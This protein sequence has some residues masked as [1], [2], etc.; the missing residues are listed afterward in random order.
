MENMESRPVPA[1]RPRPN[2]GRLRFGLRALFVMLLLAGL[3]FGWLSRMGPHWQAVAELRSLGV[4]VEVAHPAENSASQFFRNG[5]S[6][7]VA[8]VGLDFSSDTAPAGPAGQALGRLRGLESFAG[9]RLSPVWGEEMAK[10]LV[11]HRHLQSLETNVGAWTDAAAFLGSFPELRLLVVDDAW[12]RNIRPPLPAN[13]RP[14]KTFD[15]NWLVGNRRLESLEL[16]ELVA[17]NCDRLAELPALKRVWLLYCDRNDFGFAERI[18]GLRELCLAR[19]GDEFDPMAL[20]SMTGLERLSFGGNGLKSLGLIRGLARLKRLGILS[21]ANDLAE[22]R[23]LDSLETLSLGGADGYRA[24]QEGLPPNL[25]VL[26][27]IPESGSVDASLANGLSRLKVLGLR[28]AVGLEA[29][30][31]LTAL[32]ELE[33][34]ET[35]LTSAAPFLNLPALL[36]IRLHGCRVPLHV[37]EDIR[38]ESS[39]FDLN[40]T[41]CRTL[42]GTPIRL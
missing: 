17:V 2:R 14:E 12:R 1:V 16:E 39:K 7:T 3:L 35:T 37:I 31:G 41:G 10:G 21:P 23:Q 42:D 6:G 24:T 11:K 8:R 34:E 30:S 28:N 9:R 38:R 40:L 25:V 20:S 5:F 13:S 22:L 32:E 26:R 4:D 33:L 29:L 15:C 27:L 18:E 19:A 36:R